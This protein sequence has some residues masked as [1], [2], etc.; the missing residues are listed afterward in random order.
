M[1]RLLKR[2]NNIWKYWFDSVTVCVLLN[3]FII[4]Q[5]YEFTV[6]ILHMYMNREYKS[7]YVWWSILVTK[8]RIHANRLYILVYVIQRSWKMYQPRFSVGKHNR[9]KESVGIRIT[10]SW[11]INKTCIYPQRLD[12]NPQFGPFCIFELNPRNICIYHTEL[13]T[14]LT[15]WWSINKTRIRW[16]NNDASSNP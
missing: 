14:S 9:I 8:V 7:R 3:T 12:S 1:K 15:A 13:R 16:R 2:N 11:Y 5:I 4:F 6:H 10:K